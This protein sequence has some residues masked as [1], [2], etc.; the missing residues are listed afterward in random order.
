M[1]ARLFREKAAPL[2]GQGRHVVQLFRLQTMVRDRVSIVEAGSHSRLTRL[3]QILGYVPSSFGVGNQAEVGEADPPLLCED[4]M[5]YRVALLL[6]HQQVIMGEASFVFFCDQTK[7]ELFTR[8]LSHSFEVQRDF[9]RD[10]PVPRCELASGRPLVKIV[11]VLRCLQPTRGCYRRMLCWR[12]RERAEPSSGG[13]FRLRKSAEIP[14]LTAPFQAGFTLAT[15]YDHFH[16]ARD[17]LRVIDRDI[18]PFL[19]TPT[20]WASRPINRYGCG[21]GVFPC[22]RVI[23][24]EAMRLPNS[25]FAEWSQVP[26]H[27]GDPALFEAGCD[28]S[29]DASAFIDRM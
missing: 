10:A 9:S 6:M 15:G 28:V 20:Q 14:V 29:Q 1:G 13:S 24:G 8:L 4:G 11:A 7:P 16:D 2:I 22:V 17:R 5:P 3:C 18:V 19:A 27:L 25:A 23:D 12:Q 21:A 26:A